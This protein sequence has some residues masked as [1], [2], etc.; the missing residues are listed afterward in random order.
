MMVC[1]LVVFNRYI[2]IKSGIKLLH[3]SLKENTMIIIRFFSASTF[4]LSCIFTCTV[5][6]I[7]IVDYLVRKDISKLIYEKWRNIKQLY[8]WI[9]RNEVPVRI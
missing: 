5:Y 4:N 9:A 8:F 6:V 1:T 7:I 2:E 3:F